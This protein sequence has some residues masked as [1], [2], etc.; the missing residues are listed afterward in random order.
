MHVRFVFISDNSE[1]EIGCPD[2]N[3]VITLSMR[4][5]KNLQVPRKRQNVAHMRKPT[6]SM[7]FALM[8][9]NVI[10]DT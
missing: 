1:A 6:I 3:W 8:R 5:N 9:F 2:K 4:H 10:D 7:M